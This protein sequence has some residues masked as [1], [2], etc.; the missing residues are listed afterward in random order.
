MDD[1]EKISKSCL[2]FFLLQKKPE[3][4]YLAFQAP[5]VKGF[6]SFSRLAN[7]V[8]SSTSGCLFKKEQ[9]MNSI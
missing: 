5:C 2:L 4:P 3:T 6:E 8:K 1:L 7:T 9:K